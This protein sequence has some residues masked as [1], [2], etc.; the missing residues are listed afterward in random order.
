MKRYYYKAKD[1]VG[2][3]IVGEVEAVSES[4]AAKLV[5][6]KNL[7]VYYIRAASDNPFHF[8]KNLREKI[9]ISEI[10]TFTRQLS[11][12]MNAGLPITDSLMILRSQTTGAMQKVVAQIM[13]DVEGDLPC[14]LL[15]QNIP[16]FFLQPIL[17]F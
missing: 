2:K 9:S 13:A 10:A 15:F 16:K 14:Q 3:I 12:M 11:T 7:T 5:R 4:G 6:K 8:L 1:G 17:L